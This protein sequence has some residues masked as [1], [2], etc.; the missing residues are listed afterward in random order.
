MSQWVQIGIAV[1]KR[2]GVWCVWGGV[3]SKVVI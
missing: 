3:V 1:L 2:E